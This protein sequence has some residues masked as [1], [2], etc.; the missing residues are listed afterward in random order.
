MTHF[1]PHETK[2]FNDREPPWINDKVKQI[3]Q[4]KSKVYQL[5]LK[6]N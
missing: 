2:I 6:K 3:I 5:Y 4:E 1:I